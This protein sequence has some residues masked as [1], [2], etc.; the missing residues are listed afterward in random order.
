MKKFLLLLLLIAVGWGYYVGSGTD[1]AIHTPPS[2]SRDASAA[3]EVLSVFKTF[4]AGILGDTK[5]SAAEEAPRTHAVP[6]VSKAGEHPVLLEQ[7]EESLRDEVNDVLEFEAALESRVDRTKFVPA[8]KIPKLLKEAVVAA[9][10]RHFYE[11]GAIDLMGIARAAIANYTAGSTVE[12]GSTIS[13]QLVKNLFLSEERTMTRKLREL[14][15]AVQLERK[16]TKDEILALYLNTI[17][18]G[19]GTYGIGEASRTYFGKEP[20][21]LTLSE[22]AILAGLPQAP[23]AYDPIDHPEEAAKRMTIVLMLMA[24]EGYITAKEASLAAFNVL[25]PQ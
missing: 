6:A 16:Y 25:L 9:E 18:F 8:D 2:A 14:V 7:K 10:D 3:E 21:A 24:R 20:A 12:G 11:H 22:C 17:Y 5:E 4:A 23:S 1:D 13:Q 19:H 15:L